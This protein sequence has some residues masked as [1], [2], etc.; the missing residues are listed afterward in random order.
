MDSPSCLTTFCTKGNRIGLV[1]FFNQTGIFDDFPLTP[2]PFAVLAI[3]AISITGRGGLYGC[4]ML[5]IP[6]C[7]DNRLI[8]GSKVVSHTI[9]ILGIF[10]HPVFS[11][12]GL[13]NKIFKPVLR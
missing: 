4:E 5:R 6:H 13:L 7:L 11:G 2:V 3:K 10:H 1:R 8:D 12:S 9:T